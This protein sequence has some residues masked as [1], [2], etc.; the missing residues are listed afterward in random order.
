MVALFIQVIGYSG[1]TPVQSSF[2]GDQF[3]L[4]QQQVQ[5]TKFFAAFYF[6][7]NVAATIS[8]LVTPMLRAD[9]QCLGR[10]TCYSLGFG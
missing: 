4:P 9:V 6:T 3:D 10:N 7:V 5:I 1:L 8:N 2:G